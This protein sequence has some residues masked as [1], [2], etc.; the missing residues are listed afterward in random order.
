MALWPAAQSRAQ[1][2]C[3]LG[4]RIRLFAHPPGVEHA[5]MGCLRPL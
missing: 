1:A 2:N 5:P 4:V 3:L